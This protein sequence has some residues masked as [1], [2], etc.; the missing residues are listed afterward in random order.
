MCGGDAASFPADFPRWAG[1]NV[2]LGGSTSADAQLMAGGSPK[3]EAPKEALKVAE[4]KKS[5]TLSQMMADSLV[6]A[7][8]DLES[9]SGSLPAAFGFAEREPPA[10]SAA[11]ELAQ[12]GANGGGWLSSEQQQQQQEEPALPDTVFSTEWA[13]FGGD[14]TPRSFVDDD[15]SHVTSPLS[16]AHA[17]PMPMSAQDEPAGV[18]TRMT[19][20]EAFSDLDFFGEPAAAPAVAR[21]AP[22]EAGATMA[23][24]DGGGGSTALGTEPAAL[25]ASEQDLTEPALARGA[26]AS[27]F[28]DP[29]AGFAQGDPFQSS[30]TAA[31]PFSTAP[32]AGT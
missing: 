15:S 20:H 4:P 9:A 23:A 12:Q 21:D 16:Q 8:L 28:D 1:V 13:S 7:N 2:W 30:S 19:A 3:A 17:S 32:P 27:G 29:F 14:G 18:P 6:L 10:D 31:D 25:Q 5:P 11:A 22:G 26:L 24:T